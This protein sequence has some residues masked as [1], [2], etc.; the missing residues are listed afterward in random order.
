MFQLI[1]A[2]VGILLLAILVIAALYYGGGAHSDAKIRADYSGNMNTGAQIEGALRL[3]FNDHAMYPP[4][5][6]ENDELLQFLVDNKYLKEIPAGDWTVNPQTLSRP[7]KTQTI[8]ECSAMNRVAGFKTD[9]SDITGEPY[10]GCPPCSGAEG[11]PEETLANKYKSW[12]VCQ[13]IN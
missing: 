5:D 4:S 1:A 9:A 10:K 7:I 11:T 3:Y 8:E 2:V 6:L 13:L 12:P